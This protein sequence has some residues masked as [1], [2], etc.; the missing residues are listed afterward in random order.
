MILPNLLLSL[1]ATQVSPHVV[2]ML[3]A[4]LFR[5]LPPSRH[6]SSQES[7]DLDEEPL[8]IMRRDRRGRIDV[9]LEKDFASISVFL[10]YAF[11]DNR[12]N[13]PFF[14]WTG[15]FFSLGFAWNHFYGGKQ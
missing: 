2:A 6:S 15:H 3:S 11:V 9:S 4:N 8:G 1:V 13:D 7:Y 12:S 14:D 5:A 10:T